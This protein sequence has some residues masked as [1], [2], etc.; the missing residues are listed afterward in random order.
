MKIKCQ[1]PPAFA[2]RLWIQKFESF[3]TKDEWRATLAG[4]FVQPLDKRPKRHKASPRPI[5]LVDGKPLPD[6]MR[7]VGPGYEVNF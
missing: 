6:Q 7:Y 4:K 1:S 3:R 5:V 2:T